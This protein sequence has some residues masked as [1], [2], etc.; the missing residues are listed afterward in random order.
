MLQLENIAPAGLR[1]NCQSSMLC[2]LQFCYIPN[3]LYWHG[4]A[5]QSNPPANHRTS[6][7]FFF[8]IQSTYQELPLET[9]VFPL[10]PRLQMVIRHFYYKSIHSTTN[11]YPLR[12]TNETF[13][14]MPSICNLLM[15]Q[16][17]IHG[18]PSR[19]RVGGGGVKKGLPCL[20][21]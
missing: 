11:I 18:Y 21:T 5:T 9:Q 13:P 3:E 8:L 12:H 20:W 4:M 14:E 16:G 10:L 17:R 1:N 15:K 7:V 6:W 19:V 2:V